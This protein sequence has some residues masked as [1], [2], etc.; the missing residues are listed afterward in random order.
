MHIVVVTGASGAGKTTAVRALEARSI[1][2]IGCFYFDSIG[3]PTAEVM[4]REYGGGEQWQSWATRRWL[5][6]L[7]ALDPVV[8]VAVLDAQ[9]RPS[10]VAAHA[11][12]GL[13]RYVQTVLFDCDRRERDRRLREE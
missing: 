9:T 10:F 5:L 3:A 4:Q 1:P 11:A 2:G 13:K 7:D 6:Q 8:Q 12:A